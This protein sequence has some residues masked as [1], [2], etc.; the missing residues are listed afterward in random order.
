MEST[1]WRPDWILKGLLIWTAVTTI[2]FWLPFVRGLMDGPTY[3]WANFGFS[4]RGTGGDYWFPV[5][6]SAFAILVLWLGW[7]GAR[8]PFHWLLLFWHLP[9]GAGAARLLLERPEAFRFRGDTLGVDISLAPLALVFTAF[10][11]LAV[12]WVVRDL[13]RRRSSGRPPWTRTN[14][15]LLWA[16]LALAPFQ[17][18][19]LRFG[20]AHGATDGV[21]VI[22]TL[23]QWALISAAFYP[24]RPAQADRSS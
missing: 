1:S 23:L 20:E 18:L 6:G 22:L 14:R 21:G 7:R 2:V 8:R 16:A 15:R 5:L 11:L 12:Y 9:L 19:L 4:G 13:R 3:E 24:W 10:A 17:F